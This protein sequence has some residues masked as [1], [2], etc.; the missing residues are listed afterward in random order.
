LS[1]ALLAAALAFAPAEAAEPTPG[2]RGR[3][4]V[5]I[6]DFGHD[7]KTTPPDPEWW[8]LPFPITAAVM[9]ESK[10][11]RQAAAGA[12]AAGREVLIHMPFDP[13]LPLKLPA[14]A[15][16]PAD[17][18]KVA[19][20][21]ERSLKQIPEAVGLNNHRSYLGTKNRPMMAWFMTK[22]REN[23]FLF[24]DSRVSAKTVGYEEARK[25][26]VRAAINDFFLE[27]GKP[28]E[29]FC[30]KWLATGVSVAKRRGSAV[31]IGHHYHRTT[32]DCLKKGLPL[33]AAQGVD[34]VPVSRLAR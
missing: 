2:A 32:L 30:L 26:G 13:F 11:T 4:A 15:V 24:L 31:V 16:D 25:A 33:A 7:Y 17:A 9:P 18:A 10:R 22:L 5:V 20:L 34:V 1:A 3:L 19:A 14:D 23:G 6:D 28:E 8:A 29:A 12:K 21:F 27:Q